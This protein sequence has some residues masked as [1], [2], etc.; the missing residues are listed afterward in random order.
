MMEPLGME[1]DIAAHQRVI[2]VAICAVVRACVDNVLNSGSSDQD[3]VQLL[4]M[5]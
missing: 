1:L 5:L 4:P 2:C 3:E